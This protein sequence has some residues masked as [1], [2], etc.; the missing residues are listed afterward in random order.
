MRGSE[1]DG[2][3]KTFLMVPRPNPRPKTHTGQM[4]RPCQTPVFLW[5]HARPASPRTMSPVISMAMLLL[6]GAVTPRIGRV[7]TVLLGLDRNNPGPG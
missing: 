1:T 6:V 3:K 5:P 4:P 7:P 2:Q